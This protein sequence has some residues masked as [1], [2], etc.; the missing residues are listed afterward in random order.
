MTQDPD[1]HSLGSAS[2]LVCPLTC[3]AP[4]APPRRRPL[5]A[6]E[7]ERLETWCGELLRDVPVDIVEWRG[8]DTRRPQHAVVVSFPAGGRPPV[9]IYVKVEDLRKDHLARAL[10]YPH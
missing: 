7:Q 4:F 1:Q 5:A 2:L 10:E 3:G 9:V 8:D 6:E